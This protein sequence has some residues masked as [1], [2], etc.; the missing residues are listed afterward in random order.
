MA[1]DF[2][3]IA[4]H[5]TVS[6]AL[7]YSAAESMNLMARQDRVLL[8]GLA[9]ALIVVFA[10]PIRYLLELAREVERTSGLA[11]CRRSSS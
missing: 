4:F 3:P 1:A 7:G 2:L 8:G 10:R 11:L 9:L 5:F 6:G